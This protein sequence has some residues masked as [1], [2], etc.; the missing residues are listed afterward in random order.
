MEQA[1]SDVKA[2][3]KN[4]HGYWTNDRE[5]IVRRLYAAGPLSIESLA[6]KVSKTT[7]LATVYRTISLFE[8]LGIVHRI[9]SGHKELIELTDDYSTHHHHFTCENCDRLIDFADPQ[10]ESYLQNLEQRVRAKITHHH[11]ELF[12]LCTRCSNVSRQSQDR[13]ATAR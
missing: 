13:R 12:G 9:G 11:L 6:Q 10:L 4:A 8:K 7:N 1:V 2:A 3:V 5:K